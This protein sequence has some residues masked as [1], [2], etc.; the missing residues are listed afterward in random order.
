MHLRSLLTGAA[1]A[2][3][4]AAVPVTVASVASAD[5]GPSAAPG[6]ACA[7]PG[8]RLAVADFLAAHPEVTDELAALRALPAGERADARRQYLTDHPD[9]AAALRDL[10]ADVRDRWWELAGDLS[11]TLQDS[12]ALA[13]LAG[14]LADVPVGERAE[15]ARQYLAGSPEAR[16]ELRDARREARD[17]LRDCRSGG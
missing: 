3:V 11:A 6:A 17:R 10:R 13:D 7:G 1:L 14:E 15:A 2:V 16:Q 9:V 4:V 8:V 5:G 12:P